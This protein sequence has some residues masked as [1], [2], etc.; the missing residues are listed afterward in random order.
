MIN[1]GNFVFEKINGSS[2][3][4][5]DAIDILYNNVSSGLNSVNVQ[6]ALDE[7]FTKLSID[8][9]KFISSRF[10]FPDPINGVITLEEGTA[11]FITANIDLA[12]NRL[13]GS[14]NVAILGSSSETS[15]ITST[16]LNVNTALFTSQFTTPIRDVSFVNVGTGF[17]INGSG[18]D[19]AL[20]WTGVNFVNVPNIG[21][22]ANVNNFIFTKGAF[23]H[24]ENFIINGT[25]NTIAFNQSL[26]SGRG[27]GNIFQILST[28]DIQRRFRIIYSSFIIDDS[29]V[30]IDFSQ[31]ASVPIENYILDT[32][33]FSGTSNTYLTGVSNSDN[34]A[35]FKFNVGIKNSSNIANMY[36]KNSAVETIVSVQSDRYA[37]LGI[38]EVSSNIQ[39]FEHDDTNNSLIYKSP[40]PRLFKI[41]MSISLKSG[42]NNRIG[43]YLA[44]SRSGNGLSPDLDRISESEIYVTS[45]GLNERPVAGFCQALLELNENDKV[46]GIVQ[47]TSGTTNIVVEFM[48]MIIEKAVE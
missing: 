27:S 6:N 36:I 40:I 13:V 46:Y 14:N 1:R 5:T 16:G 10:D 26:F 34:K 42:N 23:L 41:Q 22:I 12:G 47:N 8:N 19:I 38:S 48:N 32:C 7:I 3:D 18:N 25:A 37:I 17:S 24:S 30:G 21:T 28:A 39:R 45:N 4:S 35:N 43:V 29:S 11:Y 44:V 15:S 20:D 2:N 9:Y 33:N 31:L